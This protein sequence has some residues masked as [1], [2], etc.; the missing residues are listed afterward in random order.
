MLWI[1]ILLNFKL[2]YLLISGYRTNWN[3]FELAQLKVGNL[4]ILPILFQTSQEPMSPDA[5]EELFEE[6]R[7]QKKA[8]RSSTT[9]FVTLGVNYFDRPINPHDADFYESKLICL[10]L[11]SGSLFF[12]FWKHPQIQL[13]PTRRQSV[14]KK[15]SCSRKSCQGTRSHVSVGQGI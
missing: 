10:D 1:W 4:V 15:S 14:A 11:G 9:N 6:K 5:L 8:R 13:L 3:P 12:L 2:Q 7:L